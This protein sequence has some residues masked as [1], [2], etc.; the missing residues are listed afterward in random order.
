MIDLHQ[1][2][3]DNNINHIVQ[4]EDFFQVYPMFYKKKI[5]FKSII[6]KKQ[7]L[8]KYCTNS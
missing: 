3:M 6:K 2:P 8:P 4:V 7:F 1:D 5:P